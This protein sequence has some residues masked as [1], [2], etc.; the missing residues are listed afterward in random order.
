[1]V[2]ALLRKNIVANALASPGAQGLPLPPGDALSRLR[3]DV[4]EL[5]DFPTWLPHVLGYLITAVVGVTIMFSIHPLITLVAVLPSLAVAAMG[6]LTW[7]YILRYWDASRAATGAMTGFLGEILGAVQ[8]I[9]VSDAESDVLAHFQTL[10]QI[11]RK[12]DL[13]SHL[14][15]EL[16]N[17]ISYNLGDL[18]FGV[19]LLLAG[20]A[21]RPGAD[22]VPDFSVGDFALFSMYL[23]DILHIPGTLGSFIADYQ[24]QAVSIRRMQELQ[25]HAPPGTLLTPGPT[26][27]HGA[28]PPVPH[29]AKTSAHRLEKLEATGVSYNYPGS[30]NGIQSV[31]LRLER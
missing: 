9:K 11:R 20:Q 8:A 12:A 15:Q 16:V 24:T 25:P 26:Y 7:K 4:A 10:N 13:K 27:M 14:F 19:V 5:A 28:F 31:N 2:Q 30:E 17:L 1:T 3:G 18:G 6:Y 22:G 21:M 29:P 23:S